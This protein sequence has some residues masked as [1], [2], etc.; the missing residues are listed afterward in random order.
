LKEKTQ[1]FKIFLLANIRLTFKIR[2]DIFL[3]SLFIF[4]KGVKIWIIY[5]KFLLINFYTKKENY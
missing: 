5:W 3:I 1:I 2:S 4:H